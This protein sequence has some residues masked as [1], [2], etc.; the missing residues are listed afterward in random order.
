[1][2]EK[3]WV[4]NLILVYLCL[5]TANN[6]VFS[7]S[8]RSTFIMLDGDELKLAQ[9][10][11]Q[12]GID[13]IIIIGVGTMNAT[14]ENNQCKNVIVHGYDNTTLKKLENVSIL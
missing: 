11:K 3:F 14:L 1:M 9:I 4:L 6:I 12:S 8:I 5:F 10:V 2:E 13:G 7:L